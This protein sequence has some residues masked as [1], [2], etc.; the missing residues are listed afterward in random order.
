MW[1]RA[2]ALKGRDAFNMAPMLAMQFEWEIPTSEV[3]PLQGCHVC[4]RSF[5][6]LKCVKCKSVGR[7]VQYCCRG[8]QIVGW[9]EHK[10]ICGKTSAMW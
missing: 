7:E 10:K 9:K 4:G 3:P 1:Q 2:V 8:H 6:E 5:P